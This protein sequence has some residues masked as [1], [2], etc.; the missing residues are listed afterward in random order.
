MKKTTSQIIQVADLAVTTL[1]LIGLVAF[2]TMTNQRTETGLQSIEVPLENGETL[3]V[4]R[5]S[6]QTLEEWGQSVDEAV[7]AFGND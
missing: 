7:E 2:F 6:R 5:G 1:L 4:E 3:I